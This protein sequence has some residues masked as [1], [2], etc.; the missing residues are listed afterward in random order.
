MNVCLS[1]HV[2]PIMSKLRL[3]LAVVARG[4]TTS[5]E[6]AQRLIMAGEVTVDGRV[7]DRPATAVAEGAEIVLKAKP[8]FVSRGG[9]KLQAALDAF[10]LDVRDA[11]CA[12]VGASTGGFTDSLLQAGAARVYA[13]DVGRGIL[14]QKLRGDPRVVVMEGTNARY[15][16]SLPE[17]VSLV[18][19]DASFISLKLILPVVRNWLT[20]RTADA[21]PTDEALRRVNDVPAVVALI[22]PQFEAGEREV[23]KG[24]GVI[25]DPQVHERVLR[26]VFA[27]AEAQGW[28]LRGQIRSPLTGPKGNVEFLAWLT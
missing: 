4:L 27:F 17:P 24:R 2:E 21:A 16:D 5:R 12:D 23:S 3:D 8:R 7:I 25:R 18:T 19:I 28:T 13:V 20:A 11:V 6:L 22:K 14:D 26:D 15:V 9:D 1:R 10:R